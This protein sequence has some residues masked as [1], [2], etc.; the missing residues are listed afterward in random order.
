ME[1]LTLH[2]LLEEKHR[3]LRKVSTQ[4]GAS[5]PAE[6]GSPVA[7]SS[8]TAGPD[9]MKLHIFPQLNQHALAIRLSTIRSVMLLLR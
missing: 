7:V 1:T 2:E 8:V 6:G 3:L 9:K 5:P 4:L